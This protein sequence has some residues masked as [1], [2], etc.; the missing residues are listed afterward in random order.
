MTEGWFFI[1]KFLEDK[2]NIFEHILIEPGWGRGMVGGDPGWTGDLYV[3]LIV[4]LALKVK[5]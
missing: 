5:S 2:N 3:K 1:Q 4:T